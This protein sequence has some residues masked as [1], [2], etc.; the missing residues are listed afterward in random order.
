MRRNISCAF[1]ERNGK[2]EAVR[3]RNYRNRQKEING[4]PEKL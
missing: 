3:E 4:T 1:F 2:D